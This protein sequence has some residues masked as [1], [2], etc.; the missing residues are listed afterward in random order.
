MKITTK[1]IQSTTENSIAVAKAAANKIKLSHQEK[2]ALS[3]FCH[4]GSTHAH[5]ALRAASSIRSRAA[6]I[7]ETYAAASIEA[8]AK[9]NSGQ[10]LAYAFMIRKRT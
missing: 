5:A 4:H 2:V 7:N 3:E 1:C 9:G 10:S 8:A 6:S